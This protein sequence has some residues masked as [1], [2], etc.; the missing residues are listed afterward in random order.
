[1]YKSEKLRL[2]LALLCISDTLYISSRNTLQNNRK[3]NI[4][5]KKEVEIKPFSK[6]DIQRIKS[7]IR[8]EKVSIAFFVAILSVFSFL[9][10]Y[11]IYKTDDIFFNIITVAVLLVV[12]Y[13]IGYLLKGFRSEIK[14]SYAHLKRNKKYCYHGYITTKRFVYKRLTVKSSTS[15]FYAEIDNVEYVISKKNYDALNKGD[16]VYYEVKTPL[17]TEIKKIDEPK[18]N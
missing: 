17:L 3:N 18:C 10:I 11:S 1:M 13:L 2:F 4:K 14:R 15:S 7:G 12:V 9:F 5:L 16:F 6:D 8:I